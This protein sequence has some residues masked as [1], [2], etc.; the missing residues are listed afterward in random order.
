MGWFKFVLLE[1]IFGLFPVGLLPVGH[2]PSQR[3]VTP[4]ESFFIFPSLM[5]SQQ[6]N[7]IWRNFAALANFF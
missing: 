3:N 5:P 2:L 4:E 7:Q 1:Q 6:C